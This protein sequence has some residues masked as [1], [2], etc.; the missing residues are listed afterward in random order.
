MAKVFKNE[1]WRA[2]KEINIENR[3]LKGPF[4]CRTCGH[5]GKT[6]GGIGAHIGHRHREQ[7]RP[8]RNGVNWDAMG[9]T[10]QVPPKERGK[11]KRKYAKRA[12]APVEEVPIHIIEVA[13]TDDLHIKIPLM[14]G[15]PVFMGAKQ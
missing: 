10:E 12:T 11:K 9:L 1:D 13:L 14:I 4:V 15:Q 7:I 6:I 8:F 5:E 2:K 3:A